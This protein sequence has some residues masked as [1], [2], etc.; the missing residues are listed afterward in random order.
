MNKPDAAFVKLHSWETALR[1][2]KAIL[3]VSI[4]KGQKVELPAHSGVAFRFPSTAL[5][6]FAV[7][8]SGNWI[9][10]Q[11]GYV[12]F[13]GRIYYLP[14]ATFQ[15]G[16]TGT[17]GIRIKVEYQIDNSTGLCM[18]YVP[19]TPP[20]LA[21]VGFG[22]CGDHATIRDTDPT[23]TEVL[24]TTAG[25][26]TWPLAS[27]DADGLRQHSYGPLMFSGKGNGRI[28]VPASYPEI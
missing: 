17:V 5:K 22:A 3:G 26:L 20:A 7:T 25:T 27:W 10:V 12:W 19:S 11:H 9:T 18:P 23:G 15:V 8:K 13:A 16:P 4:E 24:A 21:S 2:L 1:Q 14:K 28:F 6:P